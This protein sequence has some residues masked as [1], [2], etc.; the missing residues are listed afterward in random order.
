MSPAFVDGAIA[1]PGGDTARHDALN[2]ASVEVRGRAEFL[3]P[4]EIKEVL[5]LLLHHTV[6]PSVN[7]VYIVGKV[8]HNSDSLCF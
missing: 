2:G 5:L 6:C 8:Q 1:I 3:Q 7:L 4:P